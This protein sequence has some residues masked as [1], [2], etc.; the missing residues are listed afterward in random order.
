M[1]RGRWELEDVAKLCD[2]FSIRFV[3]AANINIHMSFDGTS[4]REGA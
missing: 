1:E 3:V 2:P 4:F